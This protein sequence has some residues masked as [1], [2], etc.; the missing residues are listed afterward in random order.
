MEWSRLTHA[1]PFP[2]I[3]WHGIKYVLLGFSTKDH[4]ESCANAVH[5][6][7]ISYGHLESQTNALIWMT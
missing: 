4:V 6:R 2:V 1:M 3:V 5:P 7:T